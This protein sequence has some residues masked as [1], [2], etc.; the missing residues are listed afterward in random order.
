MK[1]NNLFV[2]F[3]GHFYQPPR[4]NP[5]IEA[6]EKQFS[7]YP[8]HDWDERIACECYIP[9]S[10][11]RVKNE[12][13]RTID[14][15]NN[16]S[17]IS[18]NFGP[19][20]LSWYEKSYPE[21]Y[22]WLI[23]ADR[24]SQKNNNGHGNAIAQ[25][26]NHIIMPLA[27]QRDK[28]TQVKWG[29]K[30]FEYRF[31][32]KLEAIWIPEIACN[33]ET[34]K[35]LIEEKMKFIILAPSQAQRIRPIGRK[36][37]I[38]VSSGNIDPKRP[39]RFFLKDKENKIIPDKFV[40]IFFYD[41]P[42]SRAAAFEDILKDSIKFA[43]RIESCFDK[44]SDE[45]QIVSIVTDGESYGHHK[46]FADM[47]LAH[48]VKYEL[49][50]RNIRI[51]NFANFLEMIPTPTWE[52]E[53]KP[54]KNGEGTSWSCLHGVDRWK[55]DCG[56]TTFS[57]PGWNQKWRG[58]LRKA[59][60][61]LRDELATIFE[62]E[63]AKYL[64]DVWRARDEYIEVILDRS[65]GNIERFMQKHLKVELTNQ[66][67]VNILKLLEMQRHAMLMY[68]SCGWFFAEISG[69]ETVQ[70]LKYAARAMELA[71][72]LTGKNL[73]EKFLPVLKETKS[74]LPEFGDGWGVY[75]KLVRPSIV[76]EEQTIS[77]YAI[78]LL[79]EQADDMVC[80][81]RI[82]KIDI[83]RKELAGTTLLSGHL[84]LTSGIVLETGEFIFLL[85]YLP[86]QK[87]FC[88]ASDFKTED[89]Y[90]E[91]KKQIL[92]LT[93]EDLLKGKI[94]EIKNSFF[95]G[96]KTY[97][98]KD[99]FTDERGKIFSIMFRD[100]IE[101][102]KSIYSEL[103][104]EYFPL[105]EGS[106]DLGI[107]IPDDLKK[108]VEVT[109]TR[110]IVLISEEIKENLSEEK[111]SSLAD[112]LGKARRYNLRINWTDFEKNI[113]KI[114]LNRVEGITKMSEIS[115]IKVLRK[116][117][118]LILPLE[119]SFWRYETENRLFHFVQVQLLPLIEKMKKEK[120]DPGKLSFIEEFLTLVEL[121]G[122]ETNYLKKEIEKLQKRQNVLG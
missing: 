67:L 78:C 11:A 77:H 111:L 37:W 24:I 75:E 65:Q 85:L 56:C 121:L 84:K 107:A 54:G 43:D 100:K 60:D 74:N 25:V 104:E 31:K 13:N 7:A 63:G 102:L 106:T 3:H 112:L 81:Y 12:K 20:L 28:K 4:E 99:L 30:E 36:E 15:V 117:F 46:S 86:D 21:E 5:W 70:N 9:N 122:F 47:T 103:W 14:I 50:K 119:L 118:D 27:N 88:F 76:T 34:I 61:L 35:I 90:L 44:K 68:T 73:E 52:V 89:G 79:F 91:L 113:K 116:I 29:I 17:Y 105:L 55:D 41:G 26:Y 97:T 71:H 38:D 1:K 80:H 16:Y 48:L 101:K 40:D 115:H 19:T 72:E 53:I 42:L 59:L 82:E 10:N 108:E 114:I 22:L 45:L 32:R 94:E 87:I 57:Q 58:Q 33:Y 83:F 51:M 95:P 39:Y 69:L 23:E 110:K 6:M 98:L 64:K 2:V 93:D 109:L 120:I 92:N 49:P 62:E 66:T 8:Y 96:A 18:F